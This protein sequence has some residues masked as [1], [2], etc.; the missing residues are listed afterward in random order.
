MRHFKRPATG[1]V[2]GTGIRWIWFVL[3]SLVVAVLMVHHLR[4]TAQSV[5][6]LARARLAAAATAATRTLDADVARFGA[7][8]GSVGPAD[9]AGDRLAL[10]ARLL[11]MQIALPGSSEVFAA[12]AAGRLVA[13]SD[14]LPSTPPQLAAE[15]WFGA[16]LAAP[17]TGLSLIPSTAPWLRPTPTLVLAATVRTETGQIAGLVGAALPGV[18]LGK[19]LDRA[20]LPKG[21][22]LRLIGAD[23]ATLAAAAFGGPGGKALPA[24]NF[25]GGAARESRVHRAEP[26][27]FIAGIALRGA[28]QVLTVEIP[29]HALPAHVAVSM[30]QSAAWAAGWPE[31]RGQVAGY[32]LELAGLWTVLG[33]LLLPPDIWRTAREAAGR[34]AAGHQ[35]APDAAEADAP[36]ATALASPAALPVADAPETAAAPDATAESPPPP[37]VGAAE[38]RALAAEAALAAARREQEVAL[39]AIGHDMRTPMQ[40]VLGICDLLL[41]G[42]LEDEQRRWIE[43]LRASGAALLV[44]LNGLLAIAGGTGLRAEPTDLA[45][46]L[47][48]AA[49][50]FA[51]QAEQKGIALLIQPDASLRGLWLADAARLR[52]IVA[53]LLANAVERTAAGQVTLTAAIAPGPA[54]RGELR[55]M[56]ADTG[57][58]IRAVD[59]ERIFVRFQR[60]E[61]APDGGLGLGLALCRENATVMGGRLT[62]DSVEGAGATFRFTCPVDPQASA[63]RPAQFAGRTALIVG[64]PEGARASLRM[65]L[66]QL[67]CAVE[68][69]ADGYVG[70]ALAE[71][72]VALRGV[73]DLVIADLAMT[74]MAAEVFC[75]RLRGTGFGK[76]LSLICLAPESGTEGAPADDAEPPA[77]VDAFVPRGAAPAEIAATAA[78][79]LAEQPA[80]SALRPDPP[81]AGGG[82]VLIVED[83]ATNRSLLGAALAQRGFTP[84]LAGSGEEA[85]RMAEHAG[86]DLILLDLILPGIDGLE[87]ARRIRAL[88]GRCAS[89]PIVALTARSGAAVAAA[90]EAAGMIATLAKPIDLERLG[91]WLRG[92]IAAARQPGAGGGGRAGAGFAPD[93]SRP[94]G[95]A[96]A[97]A[98]GPGGLTLPA[99]PPAAALI[100]Q[101]SEAFLDAMA[102]E[103]GLDR[104]RACV[105]EFLDEA[106]AKCVRLAELIPGWESGPV[107]R[108]CEDIKGLADL[109]GAIGFSEA[110]EDVGAAVGS[111]AREAAGEAMAR[112][113]AGLPYLP[114][115]MWTSLGTIERRRNGRPRRAA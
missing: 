69:A 83:D 101:V 114:E 59:Q 24:P 94:G 11:R 68:T 89:V 90:C 66:E 88:P 48:A 105:Q 110:I 44:Q 53:N 82:R 9:L 42:S 10:T 22:T 32:A 106:G 45:A 18:E 60:G 41:E 67:G 55:L 29:L 37:R 72:T 54:G 2:L 19:L 38:A 23:G 84:F 43:Q 5:D 30:P 33:L 21:A 103:I 64:L 57:P 81:G 25:G 112:L 46:L 26:A 80:L 76:E 16:A 20:P 70:L 113:E 95:Y 34:D 58:G 85:L 86:L 109:F 40:S 52:Q 15:S 14:P 92:W 61:S 87:T 1:R 12:T 74:G 91:Q 50:L 7:L 35:D 71:R 107:L 96:E 63:P 17:G 27:S 36:P 6:R 31:M 108:L 111:G 115:A 51:P 65:H 99:R 100:A 4:G 8:A 49:S 93:A 97:S 102:S 79:L 28:P 98:A 77:G 62:V 75:L 47:D 56:V 78:M 13:A 39:A 3:A 73:L 104:T